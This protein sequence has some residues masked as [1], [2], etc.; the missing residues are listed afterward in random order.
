MFTEDQLQRLFDDVAG[1][2]GGSAVVFA[3][4]YHGNV[5]TTATDLGSLQAKRVVDLIVAL[6]A[7]VMLG[8]LMLM[9]ALLIK[10]DSRG[11]VF[12]RQNRTGLNGSVFKIFKFRSMRVHDDVGVVTQA[13]RRDPRVTRVGA[14]LR[15]SSLDELPQ[16]L[17]VLIGNMSV[18]GPRP[19]AMVHDAQI[20]GVF[21][22]Y[23]RRFEVKPGITGLAQI[24]GLRGECHSAKCLI[25]RIAADREY[26]AMRTMR[27]DLAIVILTV[28]RLVF[29]RAAY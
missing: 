22:D 12:F 19:H 29:D 18:V 23:S 26:I 14:F 1:D 2:A 13:T 3:G 15:R 27:L 20:A 7:L 6:V 25:D 28:P 5:D 17:N 8:P 21:S 4:G 10:L 11:P 16:F 9:I 24:R